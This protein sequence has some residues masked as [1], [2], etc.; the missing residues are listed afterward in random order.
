M[1]VGFNYPMSYNR[2]G[3][4]IGPNPHVGV[5][6]WLAER[7]LAE[8]KKVSKIPL[9]PLFDHLDRNLQNLKK[10]KIEVVRFFLLANGFNYYGTGPT[11]R[12]TPSPNPAAPYYD[13]RFIP[14]F[15]TDPRFIYH[16]ELLLQR[17]KEAG[18]KI[19]PSLISFEFGGN[20][21]SRDEKGLAP[22]GRADCIKD[23][24]TRLLFL[25][26]IFKDL[27]NLS[28]KYKEQIFAWEVIN[29]PYWNYVPIGPLSQVPTAGPFPGSDHP[30]LGGLARYPEVTF[31]EMNEFIGQ[32][33][34]LIDSHGLPSTVGHRFFR[35][36]TDRENLPW[37]NINPPQSFRYFAGSK[38]QFHYYAKPAFSFGDPYQI[39]S[40]GLFQRNP[41]PFLGEFDSALNR[42]GKPWPELKGRDTTFN[43]LELLRQEGCE[44][45][46]LWPD[47]GAP[48]YK[49]EIEHIVKNDPIKLVAATREAIVKFTGGT[50]PPPDE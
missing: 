17:F 37:E 30:A 25:G 19:I 41:K 28:K 1:Q 3:A 27:V 42:F 46:L 11:R 13:W 31:D 2:F 7:K 29:E 40:R 8:Q 35:D 4:D 26:T 10:M 23:R 32:A 16:F 34:E 39:K 14:P 49:V 9:P 5:K 24:N 20:S 21:R 47:L 45:A 48:G 6:Q 50:L 15:A 12:N 43:R 18:L 44:L 38:P 36:F 33:I 22:G